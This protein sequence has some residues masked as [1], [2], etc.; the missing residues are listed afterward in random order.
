[1]HSQTSHI[2]PTECPQETSSRARVIHSSAYPLPRRSCSRARQ[3]ARLMAPA[4]PTSP[5]AS[6]TQDYHRICSSNNRHNSNN[7]NSSSSSSMHWATAQRQRSTLM[8]SLPSEHPQILQG[9]VARTQAMPPGHH[10]A[11][12]ATH[13]PALHPNQYPHT[14]TH[15]PQRRATS[16]RTISQP[17]GRMRRRVTTPRRTMARAAH[18]ACSTRVAL[19]GYREC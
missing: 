4:Q 6:A 3:M 9:R 19:A 5:L 14:R 10:K 17:W 15:I 8:T 13:L 11:P 16:P 12:P 1:M 2:L 18:Q 7:N